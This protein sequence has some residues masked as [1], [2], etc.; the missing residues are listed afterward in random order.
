VTRLGWTSCADPTLRYRLAARELPPEAFD[1]LGEEIAEAA[2][3]SAEEPWG[4]E[5]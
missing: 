2:A 1:A 4:W 5:P 3:E